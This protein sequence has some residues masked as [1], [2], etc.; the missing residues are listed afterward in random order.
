[1][2]LSL[3]RYFKKLEVLSLNNSSLTTALLDWFHKAQNIWVSAD[4]W[5]EVSGRS[6]A[7]YEECEGKQNW[8][9]KSGYST[10]LDLLM[11]RYAIGL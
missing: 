6:E 3:L 8:A 2:L 9:W 1:M 10:V 11:V 7:G 5:F 4:S